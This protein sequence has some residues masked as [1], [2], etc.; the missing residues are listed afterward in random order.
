[1]LSTSTSDEDDSQVDNTVVIRPRPD[2][3]RPATIRVEL[4]RRVTWPTRA[5]VRKWELRVVAEASYTIITM[6]TNVPHPGRKVLQEQA[7]E[8]HG[9]PA[10]AGNSHCCGTNAWLRRDSMSKKIWAGPPLA[11]CHSS[12]YIFRGRHELATEILR[13]RGR[14][15]EG[16]EGRTRGE[17]RKKKELIQDLV[18]VLRWSTVT[19]VSQP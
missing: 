19:A 13:V 2:D 4:P 16:N 9:H 5:S 6:D 10:S 12:S 14:S 17:R 1:M 15:F 7:V 8:C 18:I 11:G 3:R